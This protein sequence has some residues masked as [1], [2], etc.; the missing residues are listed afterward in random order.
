M[1]PP[2]N[3]FDFMQ[4]LGTDRGMH[5][6]QKLAPKSESSSVPQPKNAEPPDSDEVRD[7]KR[8]IAELERLVSRLAPGKS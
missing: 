1:A 3:P 4:N 6:D 8:R 5:D 7:L 2:F